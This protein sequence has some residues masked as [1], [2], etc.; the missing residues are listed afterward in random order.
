MHPIGADGAPRAEYARRMQR[1]LAHIDAHL[2]APLDLK[3]L[4]AVAHFSPYHFHR[5][6]AGWMG[7]TLGDYLRRRRL[8]QAAALLRQRPQTAV[9][10]I[11]LEVGF[12]SGEAFARAF[13]AHYGHAPNAWRR[14]RN[15]DQACRNLDQDGQAPAREDGGTFPTPFPQEPTM[16][17]NVQVMDLSAVRIA[18]LRYTGPY[19]APVGE[20]WAH[21][22]VPWARAQQL[23]PAPRYGISHDD[24]SITPPSQCRYDAGV[25]VPERF[26]PSGDA[27]VQQ[28]PGGRYAVARFRG[29]SSEIERAWPWLLGQWLPASGYQADDRP[30][31]ERQGPGDEGGGPGLPFTCDICVP[32]RPL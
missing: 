13:K 3:A 30:C 20:F 32:L 19:G 25:E 6:F 8:E 29:T 18:C 16:M 14:L 31:F 21:R 5:V 23:A 7:E 1:V 10:S 28:L 11:A 9:L 17:L 12:G 2:A 27:T 4:A 15:P 24:P 26:V 22:F